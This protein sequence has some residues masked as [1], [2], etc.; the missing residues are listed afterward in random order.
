MNYK[1]FA[2]EELELLARNKQEM[3]IGELLCDILRP[4]NNKNAKYEFSDIKTLR[5][6]S[7]KELYQS[8]ENYRKNDKIL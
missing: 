8:L 7:D 6:I 3:T 2:L 4:K 1:F 5:E